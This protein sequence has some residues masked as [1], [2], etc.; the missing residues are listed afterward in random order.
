MQTQQATFTEILTWLDERDISAIK[1]DL[2]R[3]TTVLD[4]LGNPH[5]KLHCVHIA[6]TN[7]KGS[8]TAMLQHVFMAAGYQVGCFISPHLID[9]RERITLNGNFVDA[10]I[11]ITAAHRLRTCLER[12]IPR[13]EWPTWFECMTLLS[14][15]CFEQL[16]PDICLFEVG[17]GGRLDATNC[18]RS[19]E[20]S[21]I[22][23]IGL[24]HVQHLGHTLSAIATEKAGIIKPG[25]PV[26]VGGSLPYEALSTIRQI[27]GTVKA[28]LIVA[29]PA[30]LCFQGVSH[31]SP[32]KQSARKT[33]QQTVLQLSSGQTY[34]LNLMGLY[35]IDNLAT[36]LACIAVLR[37]AG[38]NLTDAAIKTA[39]LQ[40]NW[41]A[42]LQYFPALHL[43]VDGS[44][45]ADGF[46]LLAESLKQLFST[47]THVVWLFSLR[48]NRDVAL[49]ESLLTG[50]FSAPRCLG[51]VLVTGSPASL[52]HPAHVLLERLSG[53]TDLPASQIVLANNA[54]AGLAQ[55]QRCQQQHP[56]TL[57]I[58][59]GSLYTAGAVLKQ[60]QGCFPPLFQS[61]VA[62]ITEL[63]QN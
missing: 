37:N 62:E 9:V 48:Q 17:L 58:V 11:W 28:P 25:I 52:Y 63:G 34:T 41:P 13:T 21:V 6:G 30:D 53:A 20:L 33:V 45:N 36:V 43:V 29:N 14:F 12:K 7:G 42:R 16:Q 51:L 23:S 32:G 4:A 59:T 35:Q 56:G 47:E 40:V 26:V 24:D 38:Y 1:L 55:L 18:I 31:S 8:V 27:A 54:E 15:L 19:P 10:D 50:P 49:L 60:L 39:L 57:A 46:R 22:T 2:S 3:M 5:D 44:H 61:F